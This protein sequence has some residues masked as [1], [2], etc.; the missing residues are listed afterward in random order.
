MTPAP[1]ITTPTEEPGLSLGRQVGAVES[2]LHG[3][4]RRNA[5]RVLGVALGLGLLAELLFD[6]APLGISLP[7]FVVVFVAGLLMLAGR[8]RWQ[9]AGRARWLLAPLLFFAVMVAVRD[10]RLLTA[11]NVAACLGLGALLVQLFTGQRAAE[12]S[13][14]RLLLLAGKGAILGV[15]SGPSTVARSID[16]E[17]AGK[18]ARSFVA[19]TLRAA[20]LTVPL[21][22]VFVAL[23]MA[24]D[25]RFAELLL[26][27]PRSLDWG[28]LGASF[29]T[30][31]GATLAFSG[32]LSH[33]LRRVEAGP[34]Q[35]GDG[36]RPLRF[37]DAVVPFAA[38]SL[39]F[40]L[41]GLVRL[42]A[43][44]T[45]DKYEAAAQAEFTYANE[46]HQSFGALMAVVVLTLVVLLAFARFTRL[47][48][49]RQGRWFAAAGTMLVMLTGPVLGSGLSRLWL[50]LQMYGYT[51]LRVYATWIVLVAALLLCWRAVTLWWLRERFGV[52]AVA[53]VLVA[54]AGLNALN[55]DALVA[56]A[57]LARP[58]SI[59]ELDERYLL[60]LSADAAPVV[61]AHFGSEAGS[62]M[63]EY[64]ARV[65]APRG[66]AGWRWSR[67]R[68]RQLAFSAS[69][70]SRAH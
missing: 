65:T 45:F 68:A 44:L 46:V 27:L 6:G 16:R 3:L 19:P 48:T 64:L 35:V 20:L 38:L 1:A 51:E 13:V 57:N 29:L 36:W 9:Q 41:F 43:V 26:L 52:G 56:E 60:D 34:R 50:Y 14:G 17:S 61:L 49:D 33:A 11:G 69:R 31:L 22:V 30:V 10:S 42:E 47:E 70:T 4:A 37:T 39:V 12:A 18:R 25:A 59:V 54:W 62:A 28:S 67:A 21:V 53:A 63:D 5:R 55:P 32:L 66:L 8:E 58:A 7:L 24:G 40:G 2:H 23:L 15:L